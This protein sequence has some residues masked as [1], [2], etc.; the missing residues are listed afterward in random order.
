MTAQTGL[1]RC[2]GCGDGFDPNDGLPGPEWRWNGSVMQHR[3]DDLSPLVG[4][5]DAKWFGE[6]APHIVVA[7][8]PQRGE[9]VTWLRPDGTRSLGC[10]LTVNTGG[11]YWGDI[12]EMMQSEVIATMRIFRTVVIRPVSVEESK[13]M[14]RALQPE[15]ST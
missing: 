2:S 1:W 12:A 10:M 15:T 5:Q 13:Q 7:W 11:L 6:S 3:C 9:F 14:A 4:H 8:Q